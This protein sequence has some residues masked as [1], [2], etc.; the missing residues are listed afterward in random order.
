[1]TA[2]VDGPDVA[3][4]GKGGSVKGMLWSSVGT[5]TN[6]VGQFVVLAVLSRLLLK[7]DF[8]LV[9]AALIVIGVGRMVTEGFVGPAVT[10]RPD[11]SDEQV[12]TAFALSIWTGLATT[13][14]L[15]VAAPWVAGIFD[16][17]AM[18]WPTRA[19]VLMFVVQMFSVLPMALLQRELRFKAIA[20]AESASF[21]VGYALVGVVLAL[22]GAGVWA[23]V[24][25][26]VGQAVV[27]TVVLLLYRRHPVG[28]RMRRDLARD[29][30]VFGG[31]H[32]VARYLNFVA[33]QGDYFVVGRWMSAGALGLYNQAYQLASTPA[34]LLGNVLDRVLFPTLAGRQADRERLAENFRRSVVLTAAV[35]APL[36]AVAVV[37][38]PELIRI[39]LGPSWDDVV[40]PFQILVG[41]LT[42]R[43]AYKLS[44]AMAKATGWVYAR[45]WRQ[46]VYAALV[47]GGAFVGRHWGIDGVA[48]AVSIAIAANY[49]L[50]SGLSLSITGLGWGSFVTAHAR[51]AVLAVVCGAAVLAVATGLRAAGAP[52]P[53]VV[54]VSGV[55][56][57]AA[58]AVPARLRPG[59]VLG[60]E[61]GWLGGQLGGLVPGRGRGR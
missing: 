21:L 45:A 26:N 2:A 15:W 53:V 3:A 11:L 46:A 17:P 50:M 40:L 57:L 37:L 10:Q 16:N 31:G 20:V 43:T 35:T 59:L 51:G 7:E 36:A 47:V 25:A 13:G 49:L 8:G 1:M 56:G 5:L 48:V 22:L 18:L 19:L 6:A 38:A 60:P 14:L 41:T 61:L 34:Q 28:L 55:A 39:V 23:L 27:L 54:L 58:L 32:T 44:D 30:A 42:F 24:A 12:R 4:P 52:G 29:I 9:A 33:L